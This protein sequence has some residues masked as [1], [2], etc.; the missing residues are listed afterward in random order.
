MSCVPC[1]LRRRGSNIPPAAAWFQYSPAAAWFCLRRRGSN[2]P[3]AAAWFHT[4]LRRRGSNIP[5]AA[6][7]FQYSA[8]RSLAASAV[9]CGYPLGF[10]GP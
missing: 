7:W 9:R 6:A 8:G 3:P 4:R 10:S 2:I 5:P 1:R